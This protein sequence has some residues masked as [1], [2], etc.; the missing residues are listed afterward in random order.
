[1][2]QAEL[3]AK[4]VNPAT[5]KH[6]Y[7]SIRSFPTEQERNFAYGQL[8]RGWPHL[9]PRSV[10]IAAMGYHWAPTAWNKVID[11]ILETQKQGVYVAL[12]E[13]QDRCMNPYDALGTMRN[14]AILEAESEGFEYLC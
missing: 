3:I 5:P 8:P 14:E 6:S 10:L 2:D 13:I 7:V 11:M 4:T 12:Q 1:M 9:R